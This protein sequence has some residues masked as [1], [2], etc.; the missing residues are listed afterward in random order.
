MRAKCAYYWQKMRLTYLSHFITRQSN[1][2]EKIRKNTCK[3]EDFV[4]TSLGITPYDKYKGHDEKTIK[5]RIFHS[6]LKLDN[7]YVPLI[8]GKN[9]HPFYVSNEIDEYLKYGNWLGAPR[10]KRFFENHKIIIRQILAGEQQRI[11]AAYSEEPYYFTQIGFSLIS[12]NND[13]TMLKYLT[14]LLNSTLMSFYH[15]NVFLDLE[16]TVFQKILI[17][18]AKK[19]PIKDIND[20]STFISFFNNANNLNM[21]KLDLLVYHLYNLNYDEVL[22]IDPKTSITREEYEQ[23]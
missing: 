1:L 16:K 7:T 12:K 10:E 18:N 20:K 9:I 21:K 11:I 4:Y 23:K 15:R 19:L 17:A 3:L 13:S 14:C 8:S 2:L 5:K 6:P 22:I